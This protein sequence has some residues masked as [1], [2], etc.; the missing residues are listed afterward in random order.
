MQ[1]GA[2]QEPGCELNSENQQGAREKKKAKCTFI[3]SRAGMRTENRKCQQ[4]WCSSGPR[5]NSFWVSLTHTLQPKLPQ[6]HNAR[7]YCA[8]GA[9]SQAPDTIRTLRLLCPLLGGRQSF[10]VLW[11]QGP[12]PV[13]VTSLSPCL[14]ASWHPVNF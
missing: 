11:L 7:C 2:T 3:P 10:Q 14:L 6:K 12:Q 9:R 8:L 5:R 4:L 1:S 13:T